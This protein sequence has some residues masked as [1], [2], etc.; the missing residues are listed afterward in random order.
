M[1]VDDE[2]A[3]VGSTQRI[4]ES[5]GYEVVPFN[6]P[7]A[8]LAALQETPRRFDLIFTDM[9]MPEMS[10]VQLSKAALAVR[11]DIPIILCTG[12]TDSIN[13]EQARMIGIREL[14]LKPM[15]RR[16][17]ALLVHHVLTSQEEP[18]RA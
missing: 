14:A 15:T 18:R 16:E 12:F 2:P 8:A 13:E 5:L 9:S 7:T 11:H 1:L 17:I 3:V 6:D 4:I 10:G